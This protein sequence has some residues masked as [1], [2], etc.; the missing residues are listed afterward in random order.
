MHFRNYNGGLPDKDFLA[1]SDLSRNMSVGL[2]VVLCNIQAWLDNH[3]RRALHRT[4]SCRVCPRTCHLNSGRLLSSDCCRCT[5]GYC[6]WSIYHCCYCHIPKERV[7][8]VKKKELFIH[9]FIL[10]TSNNPDYDYIVFNSFN[11]GQFTLSTQLIKPDYLIIHPYRSSTIL[12]LEA[13]KLTSF[14]FS[15]FF[16]ERSQCYDHWS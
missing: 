13:L 9:F 4:G 7:G 14:E 6:S 10:P 5:L 11:G 1:R 16:D 2:P 3:C 15:F 8:W 12:S